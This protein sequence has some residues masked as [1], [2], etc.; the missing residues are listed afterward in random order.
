M[1]P[2]AISTA[3]DTRAHRHDEAHVL[4]GQTLAQDEGVLRADDDDQGEPEAESGARGRQR[5]GPWH[6]INRMKCAEPS[7]QLMFLNYH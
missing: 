4:T 3:S 7:G 5:R 1:T 2:A 6:G